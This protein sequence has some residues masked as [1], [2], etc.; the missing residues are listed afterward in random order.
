VED[1]SRLTY[2]GDGANLFALALTRSDPAG[3][4]AAL[5]RIELATRDVLP[6]TFAAYADKE[7][8]LQ[9]V[10]ILTLLL[11]AMVTIVGVV[12]AAG[13]AN[14]L[15]LNVTERR[16]EIGI[17]RAIGARRGHLLRLLLTEG[18]ALGVLGLA[19]GAALGYLLARALVDLTGASLF[20]LDFILTPSIALNTAALALA[21]ALIASVGPGLIAARLRPIEALRY[22]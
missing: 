20:R 13:I 17:L 22:E 18:L 21:L 1:V 8:T 6:G 12:G 2:Y 4:D 11:R 16:R 19:L 14:T 9:V 7:S 10:R 5:A 3:V 15:I